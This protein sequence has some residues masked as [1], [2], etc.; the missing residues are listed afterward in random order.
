MSPPLPSG[1]DLPLNQAWLL[2]AGELPVPMFDCGMN[3]SLP[4]NLL[5]DGIDD[6]SSGIPGSDEN[7]TLCDSK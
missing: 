7:N 2:S 3:I 6:C 5:C 1:I 4:L